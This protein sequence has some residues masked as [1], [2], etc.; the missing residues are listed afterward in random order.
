MLASFNQW[1]SRPQRTRDR[2]GAVVI[3]LLGGF[4]VALL[5]R[6]WF[7]SMPVSFTALGY[8]IA[9]GMVVGALLGMIF[10]KFVSIVMYPFALLGI[11]SN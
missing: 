3:G 8:W 4:W 10:P 6:I 1:W 11:G 2:V 5:G 9:G 7:G